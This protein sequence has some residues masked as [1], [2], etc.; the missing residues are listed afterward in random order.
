MAHEHK[1]HG[2][3]GHHH[4]LNARKGTKLDHCPICG[5]KVQFGYSGDSGYDTRIFVECKKCDLK[6]NGF[7][8]KEITNFQGVLMHPI[9][10]E[11]MAEK[12]NRR[13]Y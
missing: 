12:W 3:H 13:T 2:H 5:G 4:E 6:M 8:L 10:E 1:H 11:K 7:D 9:A